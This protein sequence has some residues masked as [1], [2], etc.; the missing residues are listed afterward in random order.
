MRQTRFVSHVPSLPQIQN[1]LS[2]WIR[3]LL[4]QYIWSSDFTFL[5]A[6]SS[7]TGSSLQN[8]TC[9]GLQLELSW[10]AL[11]APKRIFFEG[12]SW[13]PTWLDILSDKV[14]SK[15]LR[16]SASSDWH[17]GS[18]LIITFHLLLWRSLLSWCT[19]LYPVSIIAD[20]SLRFLSDTVSEL[21]WF[22]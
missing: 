16:S 14:V 3:C 8:T 12:F 22:F 20:S 11:I 1:F 19:L 21:F 13:R 5:L 17:S 4:N 18:P 2:L 10:L 6:R 15:A 7:M 9:I